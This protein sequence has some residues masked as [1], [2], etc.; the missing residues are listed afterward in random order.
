MCVCLGAV[1][2]LLLSLRA[3]SG[4]HVGLLALCLQDKDVGPEEDLGG[5]RG[6][7]TDR[8]SR[9]GRDHRGD[10]LEHGGNQ[11]AGQA[12][13]ERCGERPAAGES[14]RIL[15]APLAFADVKGCSECGGE[16]QGGEEVIDVDA[17]PSPPP[18]LV[19]NHLFYPAAPH[20]GRQDG[21]GCVCLGK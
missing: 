2:F 5:W 19:G 6:G 9:A 15:N 18:P 14:A 7:D 16:H 17:E 1:H 8:E 10:K 3:S 13:G 20:R 12:G 4:S 11:P 21:C